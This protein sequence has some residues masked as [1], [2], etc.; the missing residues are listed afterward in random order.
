[1]AAVRRAPAAEPAGLAGDQVVVD[2]AD[3]AEVESAV[4]EMEGSVRA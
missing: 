3:L 4:G 2:D 1:M